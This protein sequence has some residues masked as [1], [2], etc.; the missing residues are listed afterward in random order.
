[1]RTSDGSRRRSSK[2]LEL[3]KHEGTDV[4]ARQLL[5][6][7]HG[8]P[9]V[10]PAKPG[11]AGH[12]TRTSIRRS[13]RCSTSSTRRS[14]KGR[15]VAGLSADHGVTPIPEQLVAEGKDAGRISGGAIDRRGRPGAAPDAREGRHVDRAQHQRPLLRAGR[16]RQIRR[17][18]A[19]ISAAI[20]ALAARPGIQ[21]V[22]RSEDVRDAAKAEGSAAAR[23]R[24]QLLSRPQRRSD[25]R[26][27]PGWMIA[28]DGHDARLGEPGRPARAGAVPRAGIK[29]GR[30]PASRR[31][32]P[33]SRRRW[34]PCSGSRRSRPKA[35]RCHAC[36]E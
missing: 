31:R 6:P 5:E 36:T 13:A 29:A 12:A 1:M 27:K 23:R 35:I 9:R 33:I 18:P 4:L 34:P 30:L 2:S 28:A 32:R 8:R 11:S 3:G 17:T 21:R 16:L 15:W 24:A 7:R 22:F 26:A 10:R 14:G 25:H 19:A 20:A